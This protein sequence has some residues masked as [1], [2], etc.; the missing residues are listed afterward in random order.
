MTGLWFGLNDQKAMR[1]L[2]PERFVVKVRCKLFSLYK[3]FIIKNLKQHIVKQ[4]G[5]L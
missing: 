1:K 5:S 4:Q 2:V 3:C